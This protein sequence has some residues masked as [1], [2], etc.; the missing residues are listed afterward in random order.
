M[1]RFIAD[2]D[3]L[4]AKGN[5]IVGYSENFN[6]NVVKVYNTLETMVAKEYLS[7]EAMAIKQEIDNYRADLDNMTKT[8]RQYGEFS[9]RSGNRVINNQNGIMDEIR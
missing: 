3:L 8:I 1:G 7:P 9:I 4:I 6:E 5:Q 2:P